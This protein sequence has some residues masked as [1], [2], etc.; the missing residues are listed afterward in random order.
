[1]RIELP[2]EA[3]PARDFI[4]ALVA[5]YEKRIDELE[6]QVKSLTDKVQKLTPR[7]SSLPPST[8][9][10]HA[11][12]KR[13]P[14][15]GKKRKQGGQKGHKRHLRKLIP[16]EQCTT[17]T[18]RQPAG[19]RRC[20]GDVQPD[21]APPQRHQAWDLPEIKPIVN[22][23]QLFRG[24]CPCC[25]ITTMAELPAGVPS[26]QCGPRL[27]AFTGLL[28]GHFRQNKRRASSFLGDLLNIPCSPAWTV[29]IQNLVSDA[30]AVPYQELR[31]Q[32]AEQEQ[33][34]VD[35]SPTKEKRQKAWLWVAV[36]PMF[37][38]FGIFADRSRQSLL[39]L[40]GDYQ[41]IILNCDRAKMYLD[42]KRLQWCWA[43]LKR[44]FQ[45]LVDSP[46]GT[47]KRMGYDL[48]REHQALFRYWRQYK[49]G[50][51]KWST[52]QSYVRP[53][54][55]NI[56]HLLLRGKFSGNAK[57]IGFC[58][59]LYDRREHLWTFTRIEGIE[60]TNNTA[61]RALRPAVIYRKL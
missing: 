14:V 39:A 52:F 26:G 6:R 38:V 54:R 58:D 47:V 20:G 8:E 29:K 9:H 33:L 41:G 28:M 11:K 60:P 2:P 53:I 4:E 7:N 40:V 30:V 34:Y 15:P 22:E 32:L 36:A 42:G 49:A 55:E 44:D 1:P 19:C 10:P 56:R 45:K 31:G 18:P 57:L 35:E 25:G 12:P 21:T 59:E 37:A 27:A 3:E 51:I 48:M 13:K 17:I 46:D 61:E 50:K 5:R 43:H 23:Y 24:H 16:S